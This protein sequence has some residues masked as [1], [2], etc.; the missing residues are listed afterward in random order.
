MIRSFA[1]RLTEDIWNDV[2]NKRTRKIESSVRERARDKMAMLDMA[3]KVEA[4]RQPPSN[5][6]ERLGGKLKD[7]FSIRV[8]DQWRI[9]FQWEETEAN[10][11]QVRFT[12]YH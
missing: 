8:N 6:L 12:D 2:E 10:A 5:R 1:D 3:E 7:F 11:Y 9:I 4:L